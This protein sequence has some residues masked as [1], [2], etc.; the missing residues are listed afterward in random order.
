MFKL[1]FAVA[2]LLGYVTA[3]QSDHW[4]VIVAGS[5]GYE[6][7]RHHADACHAYQLLKKNG[8]PED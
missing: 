1:S 5:N 7:Y 8:I 2:A 6:N 4:A 3:A